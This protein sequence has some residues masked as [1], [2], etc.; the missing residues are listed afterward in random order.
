MAV[1]KLFWWQRGIVTFAP[2]P[3]HPSASEAVTGHG[4]RDKEVV[5]H[6]RA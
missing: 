2:P 4:G 5:W 3:T 6:S 1:R